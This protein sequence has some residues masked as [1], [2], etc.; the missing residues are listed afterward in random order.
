MEIQYREWH[1][2]IPVRISRR[3]Y[4]STPLDSELLSHMQTFCREFR[5][6]PQARAELLT[7]SP[8]EILGGM[9]GSYGIIQGPTAFI[10]F[11]GDTSDPNVQEKA[12]YCGE[13]II[14]EA[15]SKGL[16]TCWVAGTFRRKT[17]SAIL[18]I[19]T[20]EQVIAVT[21]L[22]H[23]PEKRPFG[24]RI[25][26]T[27][28]RAHKRKP[29]SELTSGLS[30]ERWPNWMAAALKAARLAPSAY[31]RQP[32]RFHLEPQ[33]I[34]ISAVMLRQDFGFSTRLD[35]GIAMMHIE[36][37]A[38]DCGARG[39]WEFLEPPN[40]ARYTVTNAD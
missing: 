11:I 17:T 28:V 6:F 27:I 20:N 23:A 3:R 29:L 12:G 25:L 4:I 36:V 24:E 1:A 35:C 40:V 21:P 15:T 9:V 7:Q 34:T 32:W 33:S 30:E 16:D 10:A 31:N 26:P 22:G 14:L 8:N 39:Q 19:S 37:A 2:A 13:G 18:G 38:L 5:P